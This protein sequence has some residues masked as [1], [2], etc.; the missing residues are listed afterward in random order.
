MEEESE[1]TVLLR[2]I[3]VAIDTSTHSHAALEAAVNLARILEAN[4]R[5]M[6]VHDEL[7]NQITKLPSITTVNTL[8][9]R[10][11]P[12]ESE[13][14]EDQV[15]T[16]QNR[17]RKKL[18]EESKRHM[19]E[20]SWHF[21]RGKVEEKILEAAEKADLITIGLKGVSA[22]RKVLGSSAR[23]IILEANKPVLIMKEGLRLGRSLTA[24]YDGSKESQRGINL[25][26]KIAENND[27]ILKVLAI[28]N[29]EEAR[30]ERDKEFENLFKDTPVFVNLQLMEN[31]DVSKFLNT[32]NQQRPGLL[33]AP[34][35]QPILTKSLQIILN[36]IN[37][38]LLMM[39]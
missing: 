6:F 9:G 13:T 37:C 24:V 4:V 31:P 29:S 22:R 1:E 7:W 14:L 12:L 35:N 38:P 16:L 18:E 28:N 17:L 25:A 3:L 19:V 36:H 10:V 11:L 26:L 34:K 15:K 23:R 33:I 32:I 39:N 20:H 27:T 30:K 5:G 21:T 2:E 8:T